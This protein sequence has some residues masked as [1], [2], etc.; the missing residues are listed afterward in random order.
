LSIKP[1][2]Y[3]RKRQQNWL[4]AKEIRPAPILF[5]SNGKSTSM[6]P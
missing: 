6:C 3:K 1:R 5:L 4:S 2:P